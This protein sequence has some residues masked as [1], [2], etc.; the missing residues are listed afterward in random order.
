[1]NSRK[2]IHEKGSW[3]SQ[4]VWSLVTV[5][6][7]AVLWLAMDRRANQDVQKVVVEIIDLKDKKNLLSEKMILQ[8][9]KKHLGYDLGM[10]KVKELNLREL[11]TIINNDS[12]VKDAQIYID[13]KE[14]LHISIKQKQPIVRVQGSGDS[15]YYLDSEGGVIPLV[16]GST[17][18]VP[19]A[20][21]DIGNY[22]REKIFGDKPSHLK[23]VYTMAKHIRADDFLTSLIEQIDVSKNGEFVLV[24]KIGRQELVFGKAVELEDRFDNLKIFYKEGMPKVG[25][26]KFDKLVLNWKGQ[27][28]G[29]KDM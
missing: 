14:I 11:E 29:Q 6:I 24:P 22:N 20:T 16:S 21:G 10:S 17:I 9:C 27:V 23:D 13:N 15:A 4:L 3:K 26:R 7:L 18:R 28:L 2:K 19:V 8:K 1:M 5:S 12:R 25:W